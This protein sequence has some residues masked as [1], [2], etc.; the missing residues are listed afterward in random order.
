MSKKK[1]T[2]SKKT[3][4]KA[5]KDVNIN[6]IDAMLEEMKSMPWMAVWDE[7]CERNNVPVGNAWI[8][9]MKEY[10]KTVLSKR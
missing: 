1:T 9:D 7:Y 8:A 2:K 3:N 6:D 5:K 4:T 10:E